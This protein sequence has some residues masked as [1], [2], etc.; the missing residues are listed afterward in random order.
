[1]SSSRSPCRKAVLTS[2]CS[3]CKPSAATILRTS[4]MVVIFTT[5]ENISLKSIPS[6]C[7]NPLTTNLALYRLAPS[8]SSLTLKTHL[9]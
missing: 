3:R 5:G 1:M 2:S 6:F 9:F 7:W 8:C 4:L